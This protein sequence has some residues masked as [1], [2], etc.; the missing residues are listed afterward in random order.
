MDNSGESG[1]G[2]G[3]NKEK[4]GKMSEIKKRITLYKNVFAL[5]KTLKIFTIFSEKGQ[6][7]TI[8]KLIDNLRYLIEHVK[9]E[10]SEDDN[11][12]NPRISF[13]TIIPCKDQ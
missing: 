7:F 9:R 4:T 2:S 5:D 1:L 6:Q 10:Q 8:D 3:E 11:S 12:L 13:K